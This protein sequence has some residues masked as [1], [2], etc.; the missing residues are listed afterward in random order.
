MNICTTANIPPL[1]LQTQWPL[2]PE[3]EPQP[4]PQ[5]QQ[6]QELHPVVPLGGEQNEAR[7]YTAKDW[8]EQRME[9][10]R[11]YEKNTLD[12]VI[13]LMKEQHGLYAT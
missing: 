13:E 8:V 9:I 12:K 2:Q 7:K 1:R 3:P 10:T 6:Q 11:L 4:Q 5:Q